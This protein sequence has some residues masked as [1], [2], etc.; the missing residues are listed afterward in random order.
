MTVEIDARGLSC[1]QPVM[2]ARQAI[3]AG[4]LPI[5]VLVDDET[6]LQN[7]RRQAEKAGLSIEVA[8]ESGEYRLTLDR[9]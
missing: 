1:P 2:L 3:L 6:A 4:A 5:V 9:R 7:V 8:A